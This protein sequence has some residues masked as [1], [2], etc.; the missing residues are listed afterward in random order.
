MLKPKTANIQNRTI[1]AR[2]ELSSAHDPHGQSEV[3]KGN[4]RFAKGN[5]KKGV[6]DV[7]KVVRRGAIRPGEGM[8]GQRQL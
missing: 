6:I 5:S 8:H 2:H 1:N 3:K 4:T 7:S